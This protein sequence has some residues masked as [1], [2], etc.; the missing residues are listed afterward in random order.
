[1]GEDP[2]EGMRQRRM[3][4]VSRTCRNDTAIRPSVPRP[5]VIRLLSARLWRREAPTSNDPCEGPSHVRVRE[6]QD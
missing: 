5:L 6:P 2:V 3:A 1:M 4:R